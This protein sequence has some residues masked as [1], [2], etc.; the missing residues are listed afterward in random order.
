MYMHVPLHWGP[1][2]E[3]SCHVTV[4]FCAIMTCYYYGGCDVISHKSPE[5]MHASMCVHGVE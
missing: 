3:L 2:T 5:A 1:C 4:S